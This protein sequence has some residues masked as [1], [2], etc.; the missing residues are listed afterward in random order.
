M[1]AP[2]PDRCVQHL[3]DRAELHDLV[4]RYASGVDK[5]DFDVVEACFAADVDASSW[6]FDNR[7]DLM[8]L[9]RGVAAFHTTMHMMGN[10]FVEIDG[11]TAAVDTY[12]MLTHHLTRPDGEPYELNMSGNRYVEKLVRNGDGWVI[13]Q[14]GGEPAWA[15][16][17]VTAL[18]SE[19]PAVRWLLDRAEIHDLL[20]HYALGIDLRDY[21]RIRD[22]FAPDFEARYGQMGT[23]TD[24]DELIAFIKG[25]EFFA[26]TTHFLGSQ[27][28]EVDGDRA[29]L[30]TAAMITH[31]QDGEDGTTDEWIW[32][33]SRYID[34]LERIDGRWKIT[35]R[36][37]HVERVPTKAAGERYP[38][39]GDP[40]VQ[41]LIDRAEIHDVVTTA[42]IAADRG[43][44][45]LY[46]GCF[47]SGGAAE[48]LDWLR[49]E[50]ERWHSTCRLLNNHLI[51]ID[52]DRAGAETYVY[53]TMKESQEARATPWS[54]GAWRY[55]DDLARVEGRWL[56]EQRRVES[57]RIG[58]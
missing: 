2:H 28:I 40:D 1:T 19:D 9:I 44:W 15:P 3:L 29:L 12:A 10:Q 23:F 16:T 42:A 34:A 38:S 47:T 5:R 51:G 57:N 18:S 20:M 45:A 56:I 36:G 8:N 6:G 7:D 52:G 50:H 26:S 30:E 17:G 48:H 43:D 27:L 21:E 55:V 4:M 54:R 35:K 41:R 32:G 58:T 53:L 24:I 39:S 11:D 49:E 31:R 25:V 13:T 33:G 46:E 14:R 22:C 37:D